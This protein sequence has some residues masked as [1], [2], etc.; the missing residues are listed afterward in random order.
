M[1]TTRV[2]LFV[3]LCLWSLPA[4]AQDIPAPTCFASLLK[5]DCAPAVPIIDNPRP[6]ATSDRH[7]EKM[8]LV[9]AG[10]LALGKSFDES[11]T[12][13]CLHRGCYESELSWA[14]GKHPSTS[15]LTRF[16]FAEYAATLTGVYFTERSHNNWLRWAGRAFV[17]GSVA[18][19]IIAGFHNR[20][21]CRPVG[22]CSSGVQ[23][24]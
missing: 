7:R 20:G 3:C 5:M 6:K 23:N 11:T 4:K 9:E 18:E 24:H 1:G 22:V 8:F 2:C 14:V 13:S 12:V 15:A 21:V 17:A 16:F 19:A 10:A